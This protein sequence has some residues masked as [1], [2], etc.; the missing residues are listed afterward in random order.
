MLTVHLI[1]TNLHRNAKLKQK[2]K[3]KFL[4][5]GEQYSKM[6][7]EEIKTYLF[8]VIVEP[9]EDRW[10]AYCPVL[11]NKGGATWGYTKDEALKNIREV[12]QMAIESMTEHGEK[13][14]E[15]PVEHA[16]SLFS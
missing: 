4:N 13:I 16:A 1:L 9:D 15:K 12:I 11:K 3:L 5:Y 7:K 6:V 2:S 14:P 8:K 10:I